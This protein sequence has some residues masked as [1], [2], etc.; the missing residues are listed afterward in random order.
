MDNAAPA[1]AD[2]PNCGTPLS[3]PW[4]AGCGQRVPR[5]G[6]VRA[7]VSLQ[8]RRI[9][10][11]LFA[12]ICRPGLLTVEFC[13][14][15]RARSIAPWRLL[16][17][18]VTIFFLLAVVTDFRIATMANQDATGTIAR[19]IAEAAARAGVDPALMAERLDRRFNLVYTLLL[20][21]TVASYTLVA[22][23]T[24]WKRQWDRHAIF[25]IHLVAWIFVVALPYLVVLRALGLSP[26]AYAGGLSDDL[27]GLAIVL[28]TIVWMY[29][30]VLLAFRRIYGDTTLRAAAKAAVVSITGLVM[31][32]LVIL[33]SFAVAL[34]SI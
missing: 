28:V 7:I 8:A 31:D 21:L 26:I 29:V 3:G 27:R 12:L 11:T 5:R 34:R 25:A 10:H 18:T 17:N 13:T 6:N 33:L 1:A 16:F 22:A 23:A 24:H 9:G 15:Q 14:G 20:T 32:N 4:C 30:Y 2:C 19:A